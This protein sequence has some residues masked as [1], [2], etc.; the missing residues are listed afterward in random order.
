MTEQ[1]LRKYLL[2]AMKFEEDKLRQQASE[3][4]NQVRGIQ[5]CRMKLESLEADLD[6]HNKAEEKRH[7][8]IAKEAPP[9]PLQD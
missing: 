6:R 1:Q 3:A 2:D 4:L 8:D 7:A 9:E 5:M